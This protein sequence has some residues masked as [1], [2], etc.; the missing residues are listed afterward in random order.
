MQVRMLVYKGK[1]KTKSLLLD[2]PAIVGRGETVA[3]S[4][5]HRVVSRQHCEI[6]EVGGLVRVRDLGSTN[7]TSVRGKKVVE[8]VLRPGDR[9]TIG[10]F[11]FLVD[12]EYPAAATGKREREDA[13][14]SPR[15]ASGRGRRPAAE[16]LPEDNEAPDD[17]SGSGDQ[18]ASSDLA[19]DDIS[20]PGEILSIA[21]DEESEAVAPRKE[22]PKRHAPAP[23][24]TSPLDGNADPG[25]EELLDDFLEA[26]PG[27][28]L[29][30]YLGG[31]E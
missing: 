20:P 24:R 29:E 14:A 26:L 31:I 9:F 5:D 25:F 12:Y 30:E 27:P 16:E 17:F 10:S 1:T 15:P 3:V 8:A 19:P 13:A 23:A 18:R 4:I 28:D 22:R 21:P 6:F 2:L 11:T 7:G